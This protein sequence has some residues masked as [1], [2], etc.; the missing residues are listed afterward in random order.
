M[1]LFNSHFLS[2]SQFF[3]D[4]FRQWW[5]FSKMKKRVRWSFMWPGT[6]WLYKPKFLDWWDFLHTVPAGFW[7]WSWP[8]SRCQRM[9]EHMWRGKSFYAYDSG[10]LWAV[11][12]SYDGNQYNQLNSLVLSDL[13]QAFTWTLT[14]CCTLLLQLGINV[15]HYPGHQNLFMHCTYY[16]YTLNTRFLNGHLHLTEV[17]GSRQSSAPI[18]PK[19]RQYLES[20]LV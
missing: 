11:F 16:W 13:V 19:L 3:I 7:I 10:R 5:T 8:V 12:S 9:A 20:C 4:C 18:I 15:N 14:H 17:M 6:S 2:V 1:A